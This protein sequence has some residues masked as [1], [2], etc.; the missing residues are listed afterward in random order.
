[1]KESFE[2]VLEKLKQNY[3]ESD[4]PRYDQIEYLKD[5]RKPKDTTWKQFVSAID[6]VKTSLEH[7]PRDVDE[8]GEVLTVQPTLN[9]E[10]YRNLLLRSAP[11][12]WFEKLT[13]NGEDPKTL[14][15]TKLKERFS[16]LERK[17]K[18]RLRQQSRSRNA[19]ENPQSNS[20]RG[21]EK[22]RNSHGSD[23]YCK[24]CDRKGHTDENCKHPQHPKN[25]TDAGKSK[26]DRKSRGQREE[27]TH[28]R[29]EI[30]EKSDED[31]ESSHSDEKATRVKKRRQEKAPRDKHERSSSLDNS[32]SSESSSSYLSE[33]LEHTNR[34]KSASG[35]TK[36]SNYMIKHEIHP[37]ETLR[38][39]R[40]RERITRRRAVLM[41]EI[42]P[43]DDRME[44]KQAKTLLDTGSTASVI[45]GKIVPKRYWR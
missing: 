20:K 36:Q 29:Y 6:F 23:K 44:A 28:R 41:A 8:S 40:K 33:S 30:A 3:F 11:K 17:E 45:S 38:K 26:E 10:E 14:D 18:Q 43:L 35:R 25:K 32:Y 39:G 5:V 7:F 2:S 34:K 31:Y 27:K 9:S 19:S 13:E 42:Q 37:L 12:P 1:M 24:F 21:R 15:A 22:N 16:R 4:T